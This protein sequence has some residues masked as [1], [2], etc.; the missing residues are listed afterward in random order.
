MKFIK[1]SVVNWLSALPVLHFLRQESN[2]FE[3]V[4]C[5]KPVDV[6]NLKWWG[7][8]KLPDKEI[9]QHITQRFVFSLL[10]LITPE[11]SPIWE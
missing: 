2:P 8:E 1:S 11:Y 4:I 7:L 3:D 6:T 10:V 9:R 5:D